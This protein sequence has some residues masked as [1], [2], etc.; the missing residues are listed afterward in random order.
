MLTRDG[1]QYPRLEVMEAINYIS[2]LSNTAKI[3]SLHI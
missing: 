3:A 1:M 2:T